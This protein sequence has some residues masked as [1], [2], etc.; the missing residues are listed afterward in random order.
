MADNDEDVME[1]VEQDDNGVQSS[2]SDQDTENNE[3]LKSTG[4]SQSDEKLDSDKKLL[5]ANPHRQQIEEHAKIMQRQ[6]REQKRGDWK[7]KRTSVE[8][9]VEIGWLEGSEEDRQEREILEDARAR[10]KDGPTPTDRWHSKATHTSCENSRKRPIDDAWADKV[11]HHF[12]DDFYK[13]LIKPFKKWVIHAINEGIWIKPAQ[14]PLAFKFAMRRPHMS[15]VTFQST[16]RSM[17]LHNG[18]ELGHASTSKNKRSHDLDDTPK[19]L[20]GEV[21]LDHSMEYPHAALESSPSGARSPSEKHVAKRGLLDT[22]EADDTTRKDETY[23]R[24]HALYRKIQGGQI[25]LQEAPSRYRS[26]LDLH[27]VDNEVLIDALRELRIPFH[28]I[29]RSGHL[30][31]R[32]PQKGDSF[33]L[34]VSGR[35]R[36]RRQHML[37]DDDL[38]PTTEEVAQLIDSYRSG[39][40]KL[41]ATIRMIQEALSPVTS[42]FQ[43]IEAKINDSATNS[44][45]TATAIWEE[46]CENPEDEEYEI[47][48]YNIGSEEGDDEEDPSRE[49]EIAKA[50]LSERKTRVEPEQHLAMPEPPST[51]KSRAVDSIQTAG[52]DD[53]DAKDMIDTIELLIMLYR[54]EDIAFEEARDK[55]LDSL[56]G[57]NFDPELITDTIQSSGMG[58]REAADLIW[59]VAFTNGPSHEA[60]SL[61][62]Q[63]NLVNEC[64]SKENSPKKSEN[65]D[66]GSA[67]DQSKSQDTGN[68]EF[69]KKTASQSLP[70]VSSTQSSPISWGKAPTV[71]LEARQPDTDP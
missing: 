26:A 7:R 41:H 48:R 62:Q 54:S 31:S 69:V 61:H 29:P 21:G 42:Y 58:P 24:I 35:G 18:F 40:L 65:Q 30:V 23:Q 1:G 50:G 15:E 27:G 2:D 55:I 49:R 9:G 8:M 44:T 28:Q 56:Q 64:S 43:D 60:E 36:Q 71:L 16:L 17:G 4:K 38:S 67:G 70:L 11:Y 68:R 20:K 10:N 19:K 59:T 45:E 32:G 51:R 47:E 6:C 52:F 57:F 34:P 13:S 12:I 25:D 37:N 5:E 53:A 46:A 66:F 63:P 14:L 39:T 3:K 33:I 22:S